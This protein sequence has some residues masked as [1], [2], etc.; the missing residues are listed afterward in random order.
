MKFAWCPSCAAGQQLPVPSL[1]SCVCHALCVTTRALEVNL[2]CQPAAVQRVIGRGGWGRG[3]GPQD[4]VVREGQRWPR[5][6]GSRGS[7]RRWSPG[8]SVHTLGCL[9]LLSSTQP[10]HRVPAWQGPRGGRGGVGE[11]PECTGGRG[12]CRCPARGREWGD[13]STWRWRRLEGEP[14][15]R[16]APLAPGCAL[17]PGRSSPGPR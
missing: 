15:W 17:C 3:R 11:L 14:V 16:V 8:T 1:V 2:S 9:G 6:V 12:A 10:G 5:P 13:M 4:E 7:G